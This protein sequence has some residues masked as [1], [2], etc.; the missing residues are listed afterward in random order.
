[1]KLPNAKNAYVPEDKLLEYLLSET[2]PVGKSKAKFFRKIGFEETNINKFEK[3]LLSIAHTNEVEETKEIAY[4]VNYTVKGLLKT[5][6]RKVATIKTVWFIEY[7]K[8]SP[9]FVTAIPVIIRIS[10]NNL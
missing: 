10:K 1:M 2:H 4:G 6:T 5:P 3:A 8:T 9:R 7:G